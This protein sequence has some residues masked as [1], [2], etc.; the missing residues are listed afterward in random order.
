MELLLWSKKAAAKVAEIIIVYG[1]GYSDSL[2]RVAGGR[3][4]IGW[5]VIMRQVVILTLLRGNI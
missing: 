5:R 1:T 2:C 4:W 3:I